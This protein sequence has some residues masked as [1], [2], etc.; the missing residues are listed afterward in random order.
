M[1]KARG[2]ITVDRELCKGCGICI[3]VCPVKILGF[4]EENVNSKGYHPMQCL[5]PEKCIACA[6]CGIMCPDAAITVVRE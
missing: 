5:E 1:A 6:S 2:S 3:T 4:D